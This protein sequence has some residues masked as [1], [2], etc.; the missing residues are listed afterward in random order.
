MLVPNLLEIT[1]ENLKNNVL[2]VNILGQ[3]LKAFR[4]SM[5]SVKSP[6]FSEVRDF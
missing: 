4:F 6:S 5:F 1:A 2:L 3:F